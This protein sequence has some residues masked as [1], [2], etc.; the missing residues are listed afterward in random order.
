MEEFIAFPS[1]EQ[2]RN[3]VKLAGDRTVLFRGTTKAHGTNAGIVKTPTG[4]RAQSRSQ[5]LVPPNDNMGFRAWVDK[6]AEAGVLDKL[7]A[8]LGNPDV[9]FG[10][11]AGKGIQKGVAISAVERFFFVFE[12]Y[13]RRDGFGL[14]FA[15]TETHLSADDAIAFDEARIFLANDPSFLPPVSEVTIN[16]ADPVDVARASA[17][18]AET[19]EKVEA[20]CPLGKALA[21]AGI[22]EG[23]VWVGTAGDQRL[24]FKVKGEKHS[25]S[26][27]KTLAAV[28]VEKAQSIQDFVERTVTE[29]RLNQGVQS[30]REQGIEIDRKTTGDFVRWVVAD[31]LKEEADV[32][33]ASGLSQKE[34]TGPIAKKAQAWYAKV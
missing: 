22:G 14:P 25:V 21:S 32:L 11:W 9:I 16:F 34:V 27:V 3:V 29:N 24:C 7:F 8:A 31:I 26:K 10:E 33:E 5:A 19:T 17:L 20:E 28:D 6:Q 15:F 23:V 4:Y 2:F 13:T 18:L 1:I 30:L 12:T